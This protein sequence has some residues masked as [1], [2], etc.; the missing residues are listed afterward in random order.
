MGVDSRLRKEFPELDHIVHLNSA[1]ISLMPGV[2][3]TAVVQALIDREFSSEERTKIRMARE[4][5]TRKKIAELINPHPDEI[6]L[7]SNTTEGLN[8]IAQGFGRLRSPMFQRS[9]TG[10]YLLSKSVFR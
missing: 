1:T 4:F 6:S 9:T 5:E 2:A 8:I 10:E 3:K 7:V